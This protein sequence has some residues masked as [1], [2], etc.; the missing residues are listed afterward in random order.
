MPDI[1]LI[2]AVVV[3]VAVYV[4]SFRRPVWPWIRSMR[5]APGQRVEIV[6]EGMALPATVE[7][8]MLELAPWG[9]RRL[10]ITRTWL[11][12]GGVG[13]TWYMAGDG[14][15]TLAEVIP[16]TDVSGGLNARL[17]A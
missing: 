7:A 9:F 16:Y 6:S 4:W 3:L 8:L 17:L 14:D 5:R 11:T 13:V 15:R 10:G 1:R 12:S 2:I